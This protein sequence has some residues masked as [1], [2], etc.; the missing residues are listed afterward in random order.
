VIHLPEEQGRGAAGKD[1]FGGENLRNPEF[2]LRYEQE[3]D[4][5]FVTRTVKG[6]GERQ[7]SCLALGADA[8]DQAGDAQGAHGYDSGAS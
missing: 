1:C 6:S 7:V 3:S 2:R 8:L 5:K 4:R